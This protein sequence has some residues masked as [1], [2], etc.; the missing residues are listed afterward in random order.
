MAASTNSVQLKERLEGEGTGFLP[1][2]Q[3]HA[4]VVTDWQARPPNTTPNKIL[5]SQLEIDMPIAS[6]Q[7][8]HTIQVNF[9]LRFRTKNN[10]SVGNT[11]IDGNPVPFPSGNYDFHLQQ[12]HVLRLIREWSIMQNNVEI[13]RGSYLRSR[14]HQ[15]LYSDEY[16]WDWK[17]KIHRGFIA[18]SQDLAFVSEW[19]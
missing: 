11:S 5:G 18:D 19:P 1:N 2:F 3:T 6:A 8:I 12:D 17:R 10:P 14:V 4:P 7:I 13:D 16:E 9:R 15:N